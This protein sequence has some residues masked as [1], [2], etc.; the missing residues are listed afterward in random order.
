ME[1]AINDGNNKKNKDRNDSNG[2]YPIRSHP[3]KVSQI[4]ILNDPQSHRAMGV[5][6][7]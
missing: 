6:G 4:G 3:V 7:I 2:N 1:L 5:G